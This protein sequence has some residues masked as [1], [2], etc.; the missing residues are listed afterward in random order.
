[1]N[2]E[3]SSST[4]PPVY[5]IFISSGGDLVELERARNVI[6]RLNGEF[7]G[8]AR[9]VP[10]LFEDRH[11]QA[12]DTFQRQIDSRLESIAAP[13]AICLSEDAYRQMKGRLDLALTDLGPTQPKNIAEPIRAY[14][15]EVGKPAQA[16]PAPSP[17]WEKTDPPRLSIVVLP[18]ADMA[19]DSEHEYFVDG[20][21][22]SL[23]TDLSRI[24][25]SF[26]IGCNTAFTY[27][28]RD[29]QVPTQSCRSQPSTDRLR[30]AEADW[31]Y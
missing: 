10:V 24:R 6:S 13:G 31:R 12:Y 26:V 8:Y 22:E 20:L 16:K 29:R 3:G 1:M 17:V 28:D 30:L 18:F 14:A 27:K 15:L 23:T 9:L 2:S 19:S 21:T 11:Y 4:T 25:G 7:A 5:R